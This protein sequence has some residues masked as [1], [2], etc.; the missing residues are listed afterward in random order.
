MMKKNVFMAVGWAVP[1]FFLL[2]ESGRLFINVRDKGAG[3]GTSIIDVFDPDGRYIARA[4]VPGRP[5]AWKKGRVYLRDEN[6]SGF[7]IL[8]SRRVEWR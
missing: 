4:A 7:D 8:R 3:K 1:I 2:D 6:E 5:V